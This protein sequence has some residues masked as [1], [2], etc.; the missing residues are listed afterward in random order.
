MRLAQEIDIFY[1][2]LAIFEAHAEGPYNEW[3]DDHFRQ[4]FSWRKGS[5]SFRVPEDGLSYILVETAA[6]RP[7]PTSQIFRMIVVPFDV[8]YNILEIGN[9]ISTIPISVPAGMYLL[10]FELSPPS[11]QSSSEYNFLIRLTFVPTTEPLFAII[12]SDAETSNVH[13][14]VKDAN[15]AP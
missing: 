9:I 4:G 5:V 12:K 1:N 2:Q 8:G 15:P 13:L 10:F 6:V 14:L 7:E 3:T 11:D